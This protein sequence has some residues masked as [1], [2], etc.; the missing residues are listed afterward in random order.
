MSVESIVN[1]SVLPGVNPWLKSLKKLALSLRL[2]VVLRSPLAP[3]VRNAD[4]GPTL[5][6]P[7]EK[8]LSLT[9][10]P[11]LPISFEIDSKWARVVRGHLRGVDRNRPNLVGAGIRRSPTRDGCD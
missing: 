5:P 2:T 7:N 9:V 3:P 10:F 8:P 6:P 4:P 1:V 11:S